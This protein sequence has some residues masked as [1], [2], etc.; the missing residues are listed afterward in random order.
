MLGDAYH[1]SKAFTYQEHEIQSYN[2]VNEENHDQDTSLKL[3]RLQQ[4]INE[5][6]LT[7]P[8]LPTSDSDGQIEA[9]RDAVIK[10]F[11]EDPSAVTT[12]LAGQLLLRSVERQQLHMYRQLLADTLAESEELHNALTQERQEAEAAQDE[13]RTLKAQAAEARPPIIQRR[14]TRFQILL[15]TPKSRDGFITPSPPSSKH[16]EPDISRLSRQSPFRPTAAP[17]TRLSNQRSVKFPDPPLLLDGKTTIIFEY[18]RTYIEN[19]LRL[20]SDWFTS[21]NPHDTQEHIA[22]YMTTRTEDPARDQLETLI[23]AL[24]DNEDAIDS[25]FLMDTLGQSFGDLH[26]VKNARQAFNKLRLHTAAKFA[27]FQADFF[28]LAT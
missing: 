20:N 15:S 4:G 26:K 7:P 13:L 2:F 18:W 17:G 27:S 22:A 8:Q 25:E 1:R 16:D 14:M 12:E 24:R 3:A 6:I 5:K 10:R 9:T 28:R 23:S 11:R 19:K 21:S